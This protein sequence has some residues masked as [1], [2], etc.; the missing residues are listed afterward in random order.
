MLVRAQLPGRAEP[1]P[2]ILDSGVR[3]LTLQRDLLPEVPLQDPVPLHAQDIYGLIET[4]SLGTAEF[5]QLGAYAVTF[6]APGDP[7]W[8]LSKYGIIGANLMNHGV[9]QINYQAKTLTIAERLSQLNPT[10]D[11]PAS[12]ASPSTIK[13]PLHRRE[14]RPFIH[15]DLGDGNPL[16][17]MIDTGWG[18]NIQLIQ[19]N[20]S[21]SMSTFPAVVQVEGRVETLQGL[22]SYQQKMVQ[23][24]YLSLGTMTLPNF[25]VQVANHQPG[26]GSVVIGN[27]FLRHFI[28]TL[29]WPHQTLYLTPVDADD[30]F[31]PYLEGYG[32]QTLMRDQ[33]LLITG[34][35]RPSPAVNAGLQIGDQILVINGDDYT[36]IPSHLACDFIH[37]PV[38]TRYKGP[39][40]ITVRRGEKLIT[41][42]LSPGVLL[43]PPSNQPTDSDTQ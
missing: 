15:L 24:P 23:V 42:Q 34:L 10:R 1:V 5:R 18:G 7:I 17:A 27:D 40:T 35:Y 8:C 30:A 39:I 21:T 11:N 26:P 33:R 14:G 20:L 19:Q 31:Y 38:G 4:V 6:S 28:V 29:D 3:S 43:S 22:T 2:L 37:H 12:G 36:A 25:L 16:E 32:F 41:Y 9:W 13:L